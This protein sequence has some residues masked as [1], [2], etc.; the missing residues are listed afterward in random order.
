MISIGPEPP[1]S[2]DVLRLLR[3][4]D[5]DLSCRYTSMT[6]ELI[7]GVN[8]SDLADPDFTLLVAR[9]GDNPVGCGALRHLKANVAEIKR[10]Y[11]APGF[12]RLGIARRVLGALEMRAREL[13]C[14]AVRLETGEN[15]PEAVRLYRSC[16]YYEIP[17]FGEYADSIHSVCFEKRI[18]KGGVD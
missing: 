8:S 9:S 10:M 12:R 6:R 16:G 1:D 13:A 2:K 18:G 15:Q 17:E 14:D 11:V 7:R 4:L 5:D 3:E